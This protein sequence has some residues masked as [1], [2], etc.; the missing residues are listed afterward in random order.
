M[1]LRRRFRSEE[2]EEEEEEEEDRAEGTAALADLIGGV[3]M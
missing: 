1:P 3:V 2:E